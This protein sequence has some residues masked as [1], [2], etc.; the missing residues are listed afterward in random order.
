MIHFGIHLID[1]SWTSFQKVIALSLQLIS[2]GCVGRRTW[3]VLDLMFRTGSAW[4][5]H[6]MLCGL[7][8]S[9]FLEQ[10][11]MVDNPTDD[12]LLAKRTYTWGFNYLQRVTKADPDDGV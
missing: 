7:W 10:P 6:V 1:A 4:T 2:V 9:S 12:D 5:L 8:I 3:G 11:E